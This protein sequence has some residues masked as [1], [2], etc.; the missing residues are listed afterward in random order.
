MF[1]WNQVSI[2]N[3][4]T[5]YVFNEVHAKQEARAARKKKEEEGE[6]RGITK[7]YQEEYKTYVSVEHWDI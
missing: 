6:A 7:D 1:I 5:T 2:A 3:V 4:F